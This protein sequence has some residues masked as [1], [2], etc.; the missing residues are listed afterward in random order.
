MS[1]D[2]RDDRPE[3]PLRDGAEPAKAGG[4]G[5]PAASRDLPDMPIWREPESSTDAPAAPGADDTGAPEE[6]GARDAVDSPSSARP[7][8]DK[9]DLPADPAVHVPGAADEPVVGAAAASAP[10]VDPRPTDP[11]RGSA[12][13]DDTVARDGSVAHDDSAAHADAG[14]PTTR[15][16]IG[17]PY[18]VDGD[19][20][21][22]ADQAKEAYRPRP[23][24]GPYVTSSE[25]VVDEAGVV[26]AAG[27][28]EARPTAS[29]SP[30]P[31]TPYPA[32][33]FA[34]SAPTT[35]IEP[36]AYPAPVTIA[37]PPEQPR[38]RGN[39]GV[40]TL[41]SLLGTLAFG[42]VYAGVSFLII[43]GT[44]GA[45]EYLSAFL[46]FLASAAFIAP[47]V[48]FAIAMILL[49]LIVNRAG[50]WAYV[51]GGFLVAVVVYFG[52]IAGAV[53]YAYLT[54]VASGW[55]AQDQYD[56]VAALTLD[57]LTIAAAVVAREV[58]IWT[59]AWIAARGRK[60]KARNAAAREEYARD[61]EEH[62][63]TV[64]EASRTRSAV[65]DQPLTTTAW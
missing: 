20:A 35:P 47:V 54:G 45:E 31:R 40:G 24:G 42:I 23:Q 16:P 50:W 56:F 15:S 10:V 62:E 14:E 3:F 64:A 53:G 61:L 44:V 43:S 63:R 1:T 27:A 32:A 5:D 22:I 48:M 13:H 7:E 12:T 26:M 58:S 17:G 21:P 9:G 60:L 51:L 37:T 30:A 52:A 6:S 34:P 65:G 11:A 57:P 29:P 2:D 19:G 49:V 28:G 39:R 4:S 41:I 33:A 8:A 46:A 25:P 36:E 59:G 38:M 55:G 18:V